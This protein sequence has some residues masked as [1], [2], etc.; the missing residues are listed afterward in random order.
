MPF[1][2][3]S[4]EGPISLLGAEPTTVESLRKRNREEG[5]FTAKCCGAPVVI[6]T[7]AGK[8]PHFV[9]KSVP[10]GCDGDRR[11][12]PE[13]RRLKEIIAKEAE[14][15]YEW[16]V[17]TEAI[18]RDASAGKVLW[19]AD[20]LASRRRGAVAFEVQL[21]NADYDDMRRR[22]QRYKASG[23]RGLWFVR[24]KKGFPLSHELP[25]FPV[26]SDM[27]ADWVVMMSAWD[28]PEV[29]MNANGG[30]HIE[31][32]EF[33]RAA[34][35]GQLKWAPFE[36]ERDTWLHGYIDHE[37]LGTCPGCLR[38][39][40]RHHY[41]RARIATEDGYP[42]YRFVNHHH[43]RRRSEW[44]MP[45][46]NAVWNSVRTKVDKT[47]RSIHGTCCWC[48]T[49][50]SE[51]KPAPDAKA[52][53]LAASVQLKDL[54]KPKFGTVERDWLRRWAVPAN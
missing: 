1:S 23:V 35:D 37:P 38:T 4:P 44:Y 50:L 6:R 12:T 24:T 18:E 47:L 36:N 22:Q 31:L 9:H 46:V 21:S 29:W 32:C 17:E 33:V 20:V 52:G 7:A 41:A 43:H 48:S 10:A 49:P 53:W 27:H 28:P 26:V 45:L 39:V 15:T 16:D 19:R 30:D 54:P 2:A 51:M 40:V 13:H 5:C 42:E 25:V 34:L 11:E 8:S 14:S 3:F